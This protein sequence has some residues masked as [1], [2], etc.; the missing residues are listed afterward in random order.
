[1]IPA[2]GKMPFPTLERSTASINMIGAST[3]AQ[4]Q[5]SARPAMN[6]QSKPML[7]L[8]PWR[9]FV[10]TFVIPCDNGSTA[11]MNQEPINENNSKLTPAVKPRLNQPLTT[12]SQ[13]L[14][15]ATPATGCGVPMIPMTIPR[16]KPIKNLEPQK[17]IFLF[18]L[19]ASKSYL[20][21][22]GRTLS[23]ILSKTMMIGF[24]M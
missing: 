15:S 8:R 22:P 3:L 4:A 13:V 9:R 24:I 19:A 6:G 21:R 7:N 16:R 5:I 12:N 10:A 17:P 20:S 2:S 11:A 1:M 18:N 23:K 14:A